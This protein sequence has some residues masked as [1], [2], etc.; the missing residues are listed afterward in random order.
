MC[1]L[2]LDLCLTKKNYM[3]Y[4]TCSFF[5]DVSAASPLIPSMSTTQCLILHGVTCV[6]IN[7][8][9][10]CRIK[11]M[12]I[13][14]KTHILISFRIEFTYTTYIAF[15]TTYHSFYFHT[16]ILAP[17]IVIFSING[18]KKL[19]KELFILRHNNYDRYCFPN[20]ILHLI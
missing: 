19:R 5:L 1:F 18:Y 12:R 20:K 8:A 2:R 7:G 11:C 3:R 15:F 9:T 17:S 4:R 6:Y 13:Y 16:T 14:L 10:R